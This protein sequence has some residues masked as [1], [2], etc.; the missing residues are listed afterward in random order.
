MTLFQ[1]CRYC[2]LWG[3]CPSWF[4]SLPSTQQWE[5][6]LLHIK[7]RSLL[8][9]TFPCA[10]LSGVGF[11]ELQDTT[12]GFLH[13][14]P[15]WFCSPPKHTTMGKRSLHAKGRSLLIS[16]YPCAFLGDV[17]FHGLQDS[18]FGILQFVSQIFVLFW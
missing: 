6:M 5:K 4:Y 18:T 17:G 14:Y 3:P 8:I 13:T 10:S 16:T 12:F 1:L 2:L 7:G 9:S 11:H 15:S